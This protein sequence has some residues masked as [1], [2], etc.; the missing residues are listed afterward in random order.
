MA[1]EARSPGQDSEVIRKGAREVGSQVA[2]G[3]SSQPKV[4][5]SNGV[6]ILRREYL[7][8]LAE[9]RGLVKVYPWYPSPSLFCQGP[10]PPSKNFE[11]TGGVSATSNLTKSKTTYTNN[12]Y[13]LF[14]SLRG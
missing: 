10:D 6:F 4:S 7:P 9:V 3:G 1:A 8:D 11:K 14:Y 2:G 12:Y 5:P 13:I